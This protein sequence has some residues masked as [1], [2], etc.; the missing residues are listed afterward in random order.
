MRRD[1]TWV[2]GRSRNWGGTPVYTS[3]N[4]TVTYTGPD[5]EALQFAH[6]G[7][8]SGNAPAQESADPVRLPRGPAK[9]DAVDRKLEERRAGHNKNEA[10][11]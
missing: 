5:C 7:G 9:L 10:M 3:L 2:R 8:P 1:L 4:H 6:Q 11:K